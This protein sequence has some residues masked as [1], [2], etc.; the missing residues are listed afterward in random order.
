MRQI[1]LLIVSLIISVTLSGCSYEHYIKDEDIVAQQRKLFE[2]LCNSDD[3]Y[4]VKRKVKV[5]G[6]LSSNIGG[7]CTLGWSPILE[8]NYRYAEC[9]D[10]SIHDQVIPEGVPILHYTL[11]DDVGL[12][13]KSLDEYFASSISGPRQAGINLGKNYLLEHKKSCKE[14]ALSSIVS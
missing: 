12:G 2:D 8:Y 13:C 9:I 14:S 7:G 4:F 6:Y 1:E 11:Q 5:D 10:E 3:R